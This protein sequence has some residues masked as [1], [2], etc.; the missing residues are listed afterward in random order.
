MDK[1]NGLIPFFIPHVGCPHICVF[2]NQ[3]RIAG[4]E[5]MPTPAEIA[6]TIQIYRE[7]H[8]DVFWEVA[9]YGGSF[10]AISRELQ[11]QLLQPVRRAYKD[12]KVQSIRCSTR[13]D[14]LDEA[15][16][17]HLQEY[18]LSTIELGV[19]SM[20]NHILRRAQRGHTSHD[21]VKG[22]SLLRKLGFTV[23]LQLMVGLPGEDWQSI[24]HT[25][26][27]IRQLQPDFVRIYPVLVIEDTELASDF[28]K[29]LYTPLTIKEAVTYSAFMK[30]YW[31]EAGIKV[32]RTGLQST[33]E[34]DTGTSVLGGPYA[35]AMG[36]MVVNAQILQQL[37][38][39]FDDEIFSNMPVC[40]TYPR[41]DTSKVRGNGNCNKLEVAERYGSRV[42]WQEDNTLLPGQI[43]IMAG[44]QR[45][46]L[47]H[48]YR[49]GR[50]IHKDC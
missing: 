31:E 16:L 15:W 13:P 30:T 17:R 9:F 10:T 37:K 29:G 25:T 48:G 45:I 46:F 26:V 2:C 3:R 50:T 42:T 14:A 1:K 35:P 4:T 22:V 27:A 47:C 36:E 41:C 49:P 18:G 38:I 39:V 44:K 33:A 40:I 12:G 5:G 32:I 11:E 43:V 24:V 6:D 8:S 19:Q 20:D 7:G 21:V 28:R 34:L 23:G